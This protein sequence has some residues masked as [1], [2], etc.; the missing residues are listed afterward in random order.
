[1]VAYKEA[2][3]GPSGAGTGAEKAGTKAEAEEAT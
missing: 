2:V 1:V 3:A